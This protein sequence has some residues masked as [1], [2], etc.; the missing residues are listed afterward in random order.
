MSRA[1]RAPS[2]AGAGLVADVVVDRDGFGLEVAFEIEPG[3]TLGLLGPNA[4]GKSTI[5][6][7]LA[8]LLPID[9]GHIT[10]GSQTYD[11]V[12]QRRFVPPEDR[13]LGI[14]FQHQLLFDHLSIRDNVAFGLRHRPRTVGQQPPARRPG[15]R[16]GRRAVG[17][18]VDPLLAKLEL[19]SIAERR[20]TTLSGGQAQRVALARALACHPAML[21]LDEPLAAV[22]ASGRADLRRLLRT[23]LESFNGPRLLITHDPSVAYALADRLAVIEDGLLT[24][25][26]TVAD[27]R[28]HPATPWI[29]ALTGTNLLAGQAKPGQPGQGCDVILEQG[30]VLQTATN[31]AAVDDHPDAGMAPPRAV[32]AVIDP[33]AIS[34]HPDKPQ[35]SPRN[36]WSTTVEWVEPLGPTTRVRLGQPLPLTV[37]ITT[38]SAASLALGP[39]SSI[40][41]AVKATEV[42]VDMPSSGDSARA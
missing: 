5:V 23:H 8:G 17:R 15:R 18:Q 2:D 7:V 11:D 21:I 22:D 39:G 20:P 19:S 40:W 38:S 1:E 29:A 13:D 33:R 26:G 30:F 31:L 37:D 3:T 27:V 14:V 28:R 34:L 41:A 25:T 9:A 4:A 12:E 35:G 36:S 32:R 24:Q 10:L 16:L 42:L 6:D